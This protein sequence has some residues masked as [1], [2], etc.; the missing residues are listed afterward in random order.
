M[1]SRRDVSWG[2]KRLYWERARYAVCWSKHSSNLFTCT[3]QHRALVSY[4]GLGA[5]RDLLPSYFGHGILVDGL[6]M[7]HMAPG[8]NWT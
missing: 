2:E 5:L 4:Y 1:Q 6:Y 3:L 8:S 7:Q